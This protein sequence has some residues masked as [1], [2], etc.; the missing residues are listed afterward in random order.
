MEN[1]NP[2]RAA[3]ELRIG[4]AI[5]R[6]AEFLPDGY[7]ITIELERGSGLVRLFI[8][9]IGDDGGIER[10]DWNGPSFPD[11]INSAIDFAIEFHKEHA[12]IEQKIITEPLNA[13]FYAEQLREF[14]SEQE[15]AF[16]INSAIDFLGMD[17]ESDG[18][19]YAIPTLT[20]ALQ[21][22]GC[23]IE[24]LTVFAPPQRLAR[25]GNTGEKT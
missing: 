16:F 2:L 13:D 19:S 10:H 11:E 23:K 5:E 24:K 18:A 6:A 1:Q 17:L 8:P 4:R 3:Y 14:V 9:P 22:N 20:K 7:Q 12:A 21:A 15:K 25:T